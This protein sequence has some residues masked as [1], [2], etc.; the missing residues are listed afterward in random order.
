MVVDE[1]DIVG[2]V[3]GPAKHDAPL[4]ID[5]NA[6]EPR[7]VSA[8]QLEAIARWRSQVEQRVRCIDEI[9]LASGSSNDVRRKLPDKAATPPM[10]DIGCGIVAEGADHERQVY[11]LHGV[12]AIEEYGPTE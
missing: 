3:I 7:P 9:E 1:L 12:R 4:I 8:K 10:E 2:L 11:R 5:A 6:V